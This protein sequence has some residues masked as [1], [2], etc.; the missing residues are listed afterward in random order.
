MN[1]LFSYL[2]N[3]NDL[4]YIDVPKN[5]YPTYIVFTKEGQ[6]DA[7]ELLSIANKY[8][9]YLSPKATKDETIRI[10]QLLGYKNE[11]IQNFIKKVY[12]NLT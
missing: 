8:G 10:G 11:D 2:I 5:P 7:F 4:H 3:K 12:G 6:K 9:G 1:N